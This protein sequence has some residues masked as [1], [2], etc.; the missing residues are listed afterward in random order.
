MAELFLFT[1]PDVIGEEEQFNPEYHLDLTLS[2]RFVEATTT[3]SVT[4][5][6]TVENNCGWCLKNL[7]PS[8]CVVFCKDVIIID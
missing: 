7:N 2:Y 3:I 8:Q 4:V 6:A 5:P 1:A